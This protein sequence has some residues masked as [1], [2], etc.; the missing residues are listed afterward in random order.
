MFVTLAL[1]VLEPEKRKLT[2]ASAGHLPPL[3]RAA[4]APSLS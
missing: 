3:L 2:L 1:L 4:T